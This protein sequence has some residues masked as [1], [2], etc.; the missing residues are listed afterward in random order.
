MGVIMSM[1]KTFKEFVMK[2]KICV[3]SSPEDVE[4]SSSWL[5]IQESSPE[6]VEINW[7]HEYHDAWAERIKQACTGDDLQT[8]LAEIE[9]EKQRRLQAAPAVVKR[10]AGKIQRQAEREADPA[11]MAKYLAQCK[12]TNDYKWNWLCKHTDS[13][14]HEFYRKKRNAFKVTTPP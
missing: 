2:K 6:D 1:V 5:R 4:T 13:E 10:R 14:L 12:K 9:D 3:V 11:K 7:V 8:R